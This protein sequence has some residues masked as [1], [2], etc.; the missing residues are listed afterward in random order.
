MD[1]GPQAWWSALCHRDTPLSSQVPQTSLILIISPPSSCG[2]SYWLAFITATDSISICGKDK[3]MPMIWLSATNK[4]VILWGLT[5]RYHRSILLCVTGTP[6]ERILHSLAS[7]Y[8][9]KPFKNIIKNIIMSSVH[10]T[11]WNNKDHMF[12]FLVENRRTRLIFCLNYPHVTGKPLWLSN[13][14][15]FGKVCYQWVVLSSL[16]EAYNGKRETIQDD[17]NQMAYLLISYDYTLY[18]VSTKSILVKYTH[19]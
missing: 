9:H 13:T 10:I 6:E 15:S 7:T 17:I 5:W 1:L 3:L 14:G 11:S 2:T 16:W 19:V 8:S 4:L 18:I 12:K